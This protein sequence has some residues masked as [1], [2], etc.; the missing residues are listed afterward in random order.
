MGISAR[1]DSRESVTMSGDDRPSAKADED[2]AADRAREAFFAGHYREA[3][4]QRHSVL[5][6]KAIRWFR[7]EGVAF[8]RPPERITPTAL[9][10]GLAFAAHAEL[11]ERGAAASDKLHFA[12]SLFGAIAEL[13]IALEEPTPLDDE[14]AMHEKLA[15]L[16]LRSSMVGQAE[17]LMNG[18]ELGWFDKLAEFE[19]DRE[20][21]RKGAAATKAKKEDARQRALNEAVR[22]AGKNQ[23]LSN[24]ELARRM[25]DAA[26]L[27]TTIR[28]ATDWVRRWRNDGF[29]PPIKAT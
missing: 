21:R 2:A 13:R 10:V 24:E 15:E 6:T 27:P 19:D 4:S 16:V 17:M 7:E 29:L 9:I 11:G 14:D 18:A 26:G 25:L 20:S 8:Q 5:L 22:I 23:T 12:A 28:T 1:E 3:F